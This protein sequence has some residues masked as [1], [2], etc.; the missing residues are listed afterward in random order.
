MMYK[1]DPGISYS[2]NV[3]TIPLRP[4]VSLQ[5]ES[6]PFYGF[7]V[8]KWTTQ[9]SLTNC[10][11]STSY[12]ELDVLHH[13]RVIVD[14]NYP[15]VGPIVVPKVKVGQLIHLMHN[16]DSPSYD[17]SGFPD[18]GA[19]V[20]VSGVLTPDDSCDVQP[21]EV[22]FAFG[23]LTA[24]MVNTKGTAK[25]RI[26]SVSCK[27]PTSFRVYIDN[28]LTAE[29]ALV[30]TSNPGVQAKIKVLKNDFGDRSQAV[31]QGQIIVSAQLLPT[32]KAITQ[33]PLTGSAAILMSID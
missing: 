28:P 10:P 17:L 5:V 16:N 22:D 27:Q 1:V 7:N 11:T 20:Y 13:A 26:V 6:N 21:K 30:A 15:M 3:I 14:P 25:Q 24:G 9:Y 29:E 32:G 19:N 4:G 8:N 31:K 33:G 12:T 23:T 2:G 18:I